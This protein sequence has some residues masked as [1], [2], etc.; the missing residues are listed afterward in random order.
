MSD[1]YRDLVGLCRRM[2]MIEA[3]YEE[4]RPFLI[5]DDPFVNLDNDR[6]K[7]GVNLL[8]RISEP[9]QIIYFTCHDSRAV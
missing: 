4:E 9:Y 3:M 2:A 6:V 8:K 5:L 7:G 1:G